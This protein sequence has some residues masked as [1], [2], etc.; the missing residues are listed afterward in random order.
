MN[1]GSFATRSALGASLGGVLVA[2]LLLLATPVLADTPESHFTIE[3][4]RTWA[5]STRLAIG[6]DGWSPFFTPAVVVWD[7]GSIIAGHGAEPGLEFPTQTL[8][9]V[10]RACESYVSSTGGALIADML[11]A[12]PFEI[13]ARYQ[14]T[15]DL[16]LCLVLAGGGDFKRGADPAL[17]LQELK[18]YCAGRR[19]AGF[20]VVVLTLLPRSTPASFEDLRLTYNRMV[21]DTWPQYADGLA[22]IASDSR[23]GDADD[24]LDRRYYRPDALHLNGAGSAVMATV[25]A[26]VVNDLAWRSSACEIRVRDTWAEWGEWRPYVA[27]RTVMLSPGDGERTVEMEYREGLG[28]TVLVADS[29]RVDTVRPTTFAL[30]SVRV[31]RGAKATLRYQ[32]MDAAPSG[33][34]AT[35]V[36][37]VTDR[38]G[39]V[40]KQFVRRRQAVGSPLK[41]TFSCTLPMGGYRYAVYARDAAGNPEA[42][43]GSAPLTVR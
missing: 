13:D 43:A 26:P 28:A 33:P 23:I 18:D 22:D 42:V 24:N 9:L 16:N 19:A 5:R 36:I 2:L 6:D 29:I 7:G 30:R 41:L 34:T 25:T 35:V 27:L 4:G 8:R 20:T 14:A 12:A 15:A 40:V 31:R 10:P 37:K 38:S 32:V 17:I 11:S 39:R 1:S 21:R 3:E